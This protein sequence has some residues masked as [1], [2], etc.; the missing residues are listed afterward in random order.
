MPHSYRVGLFLC[1]GC[2]T[3]ES[4]GFI[5]PGNK[6]YRKEGGK[7]NGEVSES[8]GVLLGNVGSIGTKVFEGTFGK[9]QK[10]RVHKIRRAMRLILHLID[11]APFCPA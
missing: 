8:R 6:T 9:C 4:R 5:V 1:L 2:F 11:L 7:E 3:E 10:E